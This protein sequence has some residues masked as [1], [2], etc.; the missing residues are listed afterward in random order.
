MKKIFKFIFSNELTLVSLFLYAISMAVATFVE[1]DFGTPAA[2]ELVYNATWFE[3]LQ[4]ILGLNFIG[5]IKKYKLFRKEKAAVFTFHA[6]FIIILFGAFVTRYFGYEGNM[7]IREGQ[8]SNK[9]VSLDRYFQAHIHGNG[10]NKEFSKKSTFTQIHQ[11]NFDW[12]EDIKGD[13]III[14]PREFIPDAVQSVVEGEANDA[15][16]EIVTATD[17]G[18]KSIFLERGKSMFLNG[19]EVTFDNPVPGAINIQEKGVDYTINAPAHLSYFIMAQQV[20]GST[21]ANKEDK[22]QQQA[23][24]TMGELKFVIKDIHQGVKIGYSPAT[25]K[26]MKQQAADLLFVDVEVNGEKK[27][28][29]LASLSGVVTPFKEVNLGGYKIDVSFGPVITELPFS[30][31]LNH[32]EMEKYPG[33][34]NPSAYSS[35][36]IVQDGETSYPYTIFMNNVLDHAGYRFFQ[37]SFDQDEKGTILSVNQDRPGTIITYIGYL[38]MTLAMILSL[39]EKKSRFR[40]V[41]GKL[42]KL[43]AQSV[44]L[45]I[46]LLAIGYSYSAKAQLVEEDVAI[47]VTK[48]AEAPAVVE[49]SQHVALEHSKLFGSLLVQDMDGRLKPI[50]TLSSEFLRKLTRKTTYKLEKQDGTIEMM[51]SDQLFLALQMD[52]NY[53]QAMP[54]IKV[55][56]DAG[57]PVFE[58]LGIEKKPMVSFN[59]LIDDAGDYLLRDAVDQAQ[60]KKPSERGEFDKELIKIDERFN[61]LFQGLTGNY[62]KIFPVPND[63]DNNWFNSNFMGTPYTSEDSTFVRNI[64]KMYFMEIYKARQS[65]EWQDANQ[66]LEYIRL[67][68]KKM[69]EEIYLSDT[70][71]KM[72]MLYNKMNIFNNLFPIYWMLGIYLL[73]VALWRVFTINKLSDRAYTAGVVLEMIAFVFFTGNLLLRWYIAQYPPW[74]NGYEMLIL[75]AW[76]LFLFGFIFYKKSDFILPLVSLFGGTLLFVSFLDWL[77]PEITNLVPVLKSY[78]LKIHVAIIVSSYAPLALSALLGFINLIF[79]AIRN[80]KFK[81]PILELTYVS[82]LSMTIGLYMLAIGTFLGGVWANESWGRYWGWDPKETWALIS[83]I[84]Y[85]VVLHLRLVPSLK[86]NYTFNLASLLAFSS[87]V[88]TSFGVNYYLTGL[89][90]YATGDPVPVPTFVYWVVSFVFILAVTAYYRDKKKI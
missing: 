11:P 76:A 84:I 75:V 16:I 12:E 21:D 17:Q 25:T 10:E 6:A 52:P 69:G 15:I 4:V 5:N 2:R 38:L 58:I 56:K 82:E 33:S 59:D 63:P 18:R 41:S 72:E 73:A 61:I 60:K 14:T 1:N 39:F 28:V 36:V 8:S 23:L 70:A 90:S 89:H 49:R 44:T 79:I 85:A 65:N 87:I 57:T 48:E 13:N 66:T 80:D 64:T 83:V 55:D 30:L 31:F 88:M 43:K 45:L 20:S 7:H 46:G 29:T 86:G 19:Q 9:L 37:A 78:W 68:Q 74:T 24:Y 27:E 42:S 53:W 40:L 71:I 22:L 81:K 47:E 26:K 54:I 50:N 32:F 62:L 77:N 35:E 3:I 67:F 34:E 51:N